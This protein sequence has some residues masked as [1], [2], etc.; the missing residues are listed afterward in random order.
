MNDQNEKL[1]NS[2]NKLESELSI[3][4]SELSKFKQYEIE[5]KKTLQSSEDENANIKIKLNE[6]GDLKN[7]LM[8]K[9]DALSKKIEKLNTENEEIKMERDDCDKMRLEAI[10]K[11]D[12]QLKALNQNLAN[13]RVEL[14]QQNDKCAQAEID[15][16]IVKGSN[17]ELEAKLSNCMDER[18]QLLERCVQSEKMCENFKVQNIE[19]KRKLEDSEGAL[20][21]LAREHQTL[22]VGISLLAFF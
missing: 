1:R 20:Q 18:N 8:T 7:E 5:L 9:N 10:K 12:N 15:C 4:S 19:Y 17:L 16:N 11:H 6:L 2:R 21:E 3:L 13:L 14:K 22:Q